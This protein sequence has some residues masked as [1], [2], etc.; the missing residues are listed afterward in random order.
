MS[1]VG[2]VCV[3]VDYRYLSPRREISLEANTIYPPIHSQS[4][5]VH[6][7]LPAIRH[8]RD[9]RPTGDDPRWSRRLHCAF[10]S[11]TPLGPDDASFK[12]KKF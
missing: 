6:H 12:G 7:A 9:D 4:M 3:C 1:R 2:G 10:R 5:T 8:V 11:T